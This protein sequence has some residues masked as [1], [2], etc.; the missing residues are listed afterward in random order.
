MV[1]LSVPFSVSS[2]R[3]GHRASAGLR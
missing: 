2:H 3:R 1:T